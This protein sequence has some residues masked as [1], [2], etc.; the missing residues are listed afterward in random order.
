VEVPVR[1]LAGRPIILTED[2]LDISQAVH[3]TDGTLRTVGQEGFLSHGS[4]W[5]LRGHVS[6]FTGTQTVRA[7]AQMVNSRPDNSEDLVQSLASTWGVEAERV[8][9]RQVLLRVLLLC[10][11]SEMSSGLHVHSFIH[12]RLYA[13]SALDSVPRNTVKY[14]VNW[15]LKLRTFLHNWWA[16]RAQSVWRLATG[17][18]VRGSKPG[19][20]RDF[21]QPFTPALGP[22]QLP[23]QWVQGLS[24]DE[25]GRG[26]VLTTQLHL[27]PR[28]KK[29][30]SYTST[31]PMGLRG[32]F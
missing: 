3:A 15:K 18:R 16:G 32:L 25:S 21:P 10:L 27:A 20:G 29:E 23:I 26:V 17:W 1:V 30:Y 9:L 31:P 14:Q 6:T 11:V 7:M 4:S 19:G 28:L 2:A 5:V 22:T 8:V 13:I 12:H 24:R